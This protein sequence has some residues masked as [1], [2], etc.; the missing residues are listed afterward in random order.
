[1]LLHISIP[2]DVLFEGRARSTGLLVPSALHLFSGFALAP[3]H[4]DRT[5]PYLLDIQTTLYVHQELNVRACISSI[6]CIQ[7]HLSRRPQQYHPSAH[8]SLTSLSSLWNLWPTRDSRILRSDEA[9]FGDD[10]EIKT[11]G[12]TGHLYRLIIA[13]LASLDWI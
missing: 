11:L 10:T 6:A 2:Y 9:V 8:V 12:H 3:S 7:H 1:M 5:V 13:F 4:E